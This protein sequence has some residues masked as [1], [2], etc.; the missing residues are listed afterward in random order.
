MHAEE[1]LAHPDCGLSAGA[2]TLAASAT[3]LML[4]RAPEPHAMEP[5]KTMGR[6]EKLA[7][8][9]L[10]RTALSASEAEL[11]REVFRDIMAAHYDR[12][13][14]VLRRRGARDADLDDLV[15]DVFVAF[16]KQ[17]LE[18]GFP[19]SIPTKLQSL[20]VGRASNQVRGENRA[21]V[22]LGISSSGSEKPRSAPEPERALD[23]VTMIRRLL[24]ALSLEHQAVVKAIILRELSHDEAAAE[25]GLSRSTVTARLIA[26]KRRLAV[27]A[28]ELLP[29]SQRGPG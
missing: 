8:L 9:V 28:E 3:C 17:V 22:T 27:L 5:C 21:P 20:A 14:S 4:G 11:F 25:L 26:A 18:L 15:Q 1:A 10:R 2:G 7:E 13:W 16:Y 19:D 23:V 6:E 12:V 29:A 24:P